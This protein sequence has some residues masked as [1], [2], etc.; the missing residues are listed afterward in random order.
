MQKQVPSRSEKEKHNILFMIG[1]RNKY[2]GQDI[3]LFYMI[4]Y[5]IY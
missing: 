2:V 4:L 5:N 1:N 3:I